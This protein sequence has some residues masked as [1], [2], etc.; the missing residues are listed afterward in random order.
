MNATE[1]K[2]AAIAAYRAHPGINA[3]TLKAARTSMLHARHAYR[4]GYAD[5]TAAMELGTA[6]HAMLSCIAGTSPVCGVVRYDGRRAGKEWEAFAAANASALILP[7]AAYDSAVAMHDGARPL[8]DAVVKSGGAGEFERPIF[9]TA[10]GVSCKALPDLIQEGVLL[11]IK[12]TTDIR[13]RTIEAQAEKMGWW[14]Q[15]G[16]YLAAYE[17][18]MPK[19]RRPDIYIL[20]IESKPPYDS[21]LYRMDDDSIDQGRKEAFILARRFA[22]C[23]SAGEFPGIANGKTL[24]LTRPEWTQTDSVDLSDINPEE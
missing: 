14:L 18:D 23:L 1:N 8:L 6:V 19:A 16:W 24:A 7:A 22:A 21:A 2:A 10:Y 3:T 20:A 12:T 13:E 15:L 9:W 11:D 4:R 5:P 17:S